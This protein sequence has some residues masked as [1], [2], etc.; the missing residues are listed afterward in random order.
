MKNKKMKI[1]LVKKKLIENFDAVKTVH[2]KY[3][4]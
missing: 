2:L 4:I 1:Y 3:D